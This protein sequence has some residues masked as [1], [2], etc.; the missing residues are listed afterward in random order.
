MPRLACVE[1]RGTVQNNNIL[2]V[3]LVDLARSLPVGWGTDRP[4]SIFVV[5]PTSYQ[6]VTRYRSFQIPLR[7]GMSAE[8]LTKA[9]KCY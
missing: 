5:V 1:D 4:C 9:H 8:T 6:D 3:R 7:I 2:N